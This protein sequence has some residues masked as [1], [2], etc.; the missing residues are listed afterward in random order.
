[1]NYIK[2]RTGTSFERFVS[3]AMHTMPF[4]AITVIIANYGVMGWATAALLTKLLGNIETG[5]YIAWAVGIVASLGRGSL[6][7]LPNFDPDKP[8]FSKR[9]ELSAVVF[10]IAFIYEIIHLTIGNGVSGTVAFSL[11]ILAV[12]GCVIEILAVGNIKMKHNS[13][14]ANDPERVQRYVNSMSGIA[15]M[16][17]LEDQVR[18]AMRQEGQFFDSSDFERYLNLPKQ[19][20]PPSALPENTSGKKPENGQMD[21]SDFREYKAGNGQH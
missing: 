12:M 7:F 14:I 9:G 3:S 13:D 8:D 20:A 17:A 2:R 5:Y 18:A 1:M 10:T 6:V 4:I 19:A 11:G 15:N 21:F 16:E